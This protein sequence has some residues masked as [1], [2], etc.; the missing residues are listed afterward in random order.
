MST[1][2]D[3]RKLIAAMPDILRSMHFYAPS[4]PIDTD[5]L[6]HGGLEALA[7][8]LRD[9]LTVLLAENDAL[10]TRVAELEAERAAERNAARV[11]GVRLGLEAGAKRVETMII[12]GRAWTEEQ[13]VAA[14]ALLAAIAA[15]GALDATEIAKGG[16]P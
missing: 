10:R 8:Q 5:N 13:G 12:G 11:E 15:I 9:D 14:H 2:D 7:Y 1:H 3:I 6:D 4:A 16:T